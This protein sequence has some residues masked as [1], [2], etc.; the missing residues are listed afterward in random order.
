MSLSTRVRDESGFGL[1]E[2]LIAM[3]VMV[4]GITALVAGFSS[5]M[6]ALKRAAQGVDRGRACGQADGALPALSYT[7]IT[8]TCPIAAPASTDCFGSST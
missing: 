8:S 2:L 4:I 1:V 5:G 6:L 3:A 7:S